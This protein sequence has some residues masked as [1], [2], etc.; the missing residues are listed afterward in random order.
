MPFFAGTMTDGAYILVEYEG[1]LS[2]EEIEA[3]RLSAQRLLET[4]D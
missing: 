2:R 4:Y 1:T 3:G